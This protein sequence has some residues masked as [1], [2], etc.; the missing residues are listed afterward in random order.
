METFNE[1][2]EILKQ[3][4][5]CVTAWLIL[6]IVANSLTAVTYLFLSDKITK[7]MTTEVPESMIIVLGVLGIFNVLF[8]VMLFQWRKIAFWGF[9]VTSLC[10][11]LFNLVNGLGIGQSLGGLLGVAVLYAVL[12]MKKDN[13]SAWENLK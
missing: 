11:F 2:P 7:L 9:V 10:S 5:G 13:V 4:H 1:N 12:Q 8:S 6:M 3:R